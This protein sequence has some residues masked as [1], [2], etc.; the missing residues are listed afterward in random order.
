M[1]VDTNCDS[2]KGFTCK[3]RTAPFIMVD[4][5]SNSILYDPLM[6]KVFE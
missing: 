1:F 5:D 2:F 4:I 3:D 6:N